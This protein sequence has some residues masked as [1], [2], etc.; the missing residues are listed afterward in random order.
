MTFVKINENLF[1]A[2]ITGKMLDP[3]WDNRQT[4]T[5]TVTSDYFTIASQFVNNAKWSIV[6]IDEQD[7]SNRAEYDNSDFI[8]AGDIVDHRDGTISVTMGKLNELE[9]AYE[10]IFGGLTN[11]N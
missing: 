2:I 4:K 10:I 6:E 5:I 8:L 11:V 1:P 7:D 9:E 3:D